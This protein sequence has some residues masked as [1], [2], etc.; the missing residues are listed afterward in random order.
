MHLTQLNE[1][2]MLVKLTMRRANL[3]RRDQAAEALVQAQ[4]DDQSLIV[5][6]KLFRDKNNPINK[7]MSAVSEV[8]EW[9]KKNTLPYIDK[10]P[11]ILPNNNYMEYTQTMR[12]KIAVVD[13]L[14]QQHMPNWDMYVAQDIKFRS[15]LP[16]SRAK[17]EDYPTAE[18]FQSKMGFDMRFMPLPDAKHFLFDISD[19][20]IHGFEQSMAEA[21]TVAKDDTIKRM[22]EP[23]GKLVSKLNTPIGSEGSIFRDSALENVVEG[24]EVARKLSIDASPELQGLIAQLDNEMSKYVQRKDWL[25]DSPP[26]RKQAADKLDEIARQMGAFMGM[27]LVEH[28]EAA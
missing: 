2:A 17:A 27:T 23:L 22:L 18:Q 8:Y 16:N 5:N 10:G 12:H 15:H 19:E 7:I 24:I 13:K 21:M 3:T 1:K 25:R 9:H 4:M 26:M 11:R 28:K 6:S 14:L 20:D